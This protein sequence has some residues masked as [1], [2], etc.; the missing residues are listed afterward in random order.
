MSEGAVNPPVFLTST[1]V[2]M[3]AEDGNDFFDFVS[4]RRER[5]A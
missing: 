4:G 1:V 3:T 5:G 2:F